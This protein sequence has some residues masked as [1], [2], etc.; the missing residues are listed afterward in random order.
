MTADSES[1]WVVIEQREVTMMGQRPAAVPT[2]QLENDK[3]IVTQW[4]FAPGGGDR[5]ARP[6]I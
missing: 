1:G 6:S 3:V 4:R 2:L 5:L